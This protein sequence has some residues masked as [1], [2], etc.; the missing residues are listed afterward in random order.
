MFYSTRAFSLATTQGLIL[1]VGNACYGVVLDMVERIVRAKLDDLTTVE[2]QEVLYL[3]QN[4]ISVTSLAALLQY[5]QHL[6]NNRQRAYPIVILRAGT[7]RL[8]MIVD[9]IP[10]EIP[11]IVKPMGPQ[12]EHMKLYAGGSIL[13]DGSVLP[14]LEARHVITMI[15][16]GGS[17]YKTTDNQDNAADA[18][19]PRYGDKNQESRTERSAILVVD[20]SITTR[21]LERNILEA[22]GY[23]VLVATDGIEAADILRMEDNIA[24]VVTDLE[25]PRM[26]GIE[27]C[28]HIRSGTKKHL[29]IIMVTSVGTESEKE[30][31][32]K[33]GADAYIIKGNFQQD[34]FLSTVRRF[35]NI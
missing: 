26:T 28:K 1:Q 4:P 7:M 18:D 3:D 27:L 31:G 16:S 23:R 14:V 2:G 6:P 34:H 12:F 24:L 29:P 17:I 8:A 13:A 30:K 21:T 32:L 11:M 19:S 33:A 5:R 22:A 20:D 15:S 10:G 25:M 35:V 9:D